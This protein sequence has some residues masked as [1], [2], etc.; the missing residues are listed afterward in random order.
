MSQMGERER[1][2]KWAMGL[3]DNTQRNECEGKG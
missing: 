1:V 2:R 3:M